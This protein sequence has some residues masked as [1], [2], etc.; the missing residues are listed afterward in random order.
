MGRTDAPHTP[1]GRSR[2]WHS[3]ERT[4][5]RRYR[6]AAVTSPSASQQRVA[7]QLQQGQFSIDIIDSIDIIGIIDIIASQSHHIIGRPPLPA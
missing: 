6:R 5:W 7:R 1:L 4:S 3:A 2:Y